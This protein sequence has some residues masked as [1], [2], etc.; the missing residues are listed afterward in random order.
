[1]ELARD[2]LDGEL[3]KEEDTCAKHDTKRELCDDGDGGRLGALDVD[4]DEGIE[5]C[6]DGDCP[7]EEGYVSLYCLG[8]D[9]NEDVK[10]PSERRDL[11]MQSLQPVDI[12]PAT[13]GDDSDGSSDDAGSN[14]T[15]RSLSS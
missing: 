1:M 5:G 15:V 2:P 8:S 11:P 14:T 7:C 9:F 3:L 6:P 10:K 13:D 12:A 4:V